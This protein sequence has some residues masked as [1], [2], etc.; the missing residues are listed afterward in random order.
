MLVLL[1]LKNIHD[2]TK[3]GRQQFSI[4]TIIMSKEA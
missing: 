3:A 1:Q 2:F 4:D